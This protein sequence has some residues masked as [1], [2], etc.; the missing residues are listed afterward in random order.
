MRKVFISKFDNVMVRGLF[1]KGF[2]GPRDFFKGFFGPQPKKVWEALP[3]IL[4]I[5]P[6]PKVCLF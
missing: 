1:L 3:Y 4:T 6:Y 2:Y 5:N